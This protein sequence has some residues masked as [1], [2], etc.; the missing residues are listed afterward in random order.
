MRVC[1]IGLALAVAACD[2]G[3]FEGPLATAADSILQGAP[4]GRCDTIRVES[5][6]PTARLPLQSCGATRG[7]TTLSLVLDDDKRVLVIS[8]TTRVDPTLQRAVHD[9]LQFAVGDAYGAPVI[10]AQGNDSAETEVRLWNTLDRQI[11]LKNSGR[12]RI[13]F[14]RRTDHPQCRRAG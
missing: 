3:S 10:C 11:V 13:V 7:D 4:L 14:E 6:F 12:D 1:M 8:R 9:S 5:A 2:Q